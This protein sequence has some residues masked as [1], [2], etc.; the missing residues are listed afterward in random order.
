MGMLVGKRKRAIARGT[1]K[2]GT[3]R[4]FLNGRPLETVLPELYQLRVREASLILPHLA[5][6]ID[7]HIH[8]EGGGIAGQA[9]AARIIVAKA[10]V[11]VAGKQRE[12]VEHI[13]ESYDRTLLVAD[14]RL[15]EK[16]KPNTHGKA[17]AKRQKSYR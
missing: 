13:L 2:K 9:D 4:I 1:W 6:K 10:L 14:V 16:R 8:V 3:G 17:R 7:V 12:Q 15:K 11:E 5:E